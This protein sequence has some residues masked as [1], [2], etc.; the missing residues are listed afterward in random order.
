[1]SQANR[2]SRRSFL[3]SALVTSVGATLVACVAPPVG[4]TTTTGEAAPAGEKVTLEFWCSLSGDAWTELVNIFNEAHPDIEAIYT[5]TPSVTT[6]GTNPK[7]LAATL[8]GN[9]PDVFLHDGSSYST[10]VALNAFEQIDD[11]AAA[12]N[13]TSDLYWA[14]FWPKVIWNGHLYGLPFDTDARALYWNKAL[15]GEAGFSEPPKTIAEL[16]AMAETLTIG[17]RESGYDQVGFIPWA[18]N[19]RITGWGW[20]RGAQ[21][22]DEDAQK[23]HLNAPEIIA[24]MEWEATYAQK[25]G[26]E[27]LTSFTQSVSGESTDPFISGVLPLMV[28][29]DWEI[30]NL[31]RYA[32]DLEYGIAPT[33]VVEGRDFMT[34]SGGFVNGIPTGVHHIEQSWEF[35]K[36]MGGKDAQLTYAKATSHMCT[37][38]EAQEEFVAFDPDHQVF[39]DLLPTTVIEPVFPEWALVEDGIPSEQEVLYGRKTAQ[40]AFDELNIKVQ[41][42]VDTRLAG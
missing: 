16:D 36:F 28:T 27:E 3:R 32:P 7:F 20:S 40:E 11:L 21:Y 38:I 2:I 14:A 34:W 6:P 23:S 26:I 13:I 17:T 42:A 22:W 41:T 37:N 18:G 25:Y 8:G 31:K 29:G 33:P 15:L 9:P 24:A 35:L 30:A 1:M 39:T 10:S 19:W 4:Q 5:F 12:D